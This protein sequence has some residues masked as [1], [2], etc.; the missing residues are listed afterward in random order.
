MT[1]RS[2]PTASRSRIRASSYSGLISARLGSAQRLTGSMGPKT[3]ETDPG[4]GALE[5]RA[6]TT[7]FSG[8]ML[9]NLYVMPGSM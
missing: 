4:N 9:Y 2:V 6:T 3:V 5:A 7:D 1:L 8:G